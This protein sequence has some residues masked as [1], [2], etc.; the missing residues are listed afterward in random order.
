MCFV[1]PKD[2]VKTDWKVIILAKMCLDFK[3]KARFDTRC[4]HSLD[5]W[6]TIDIFSKAVESSKL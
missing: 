3:P 5:F 2:V 6:L 4:Y 1:D